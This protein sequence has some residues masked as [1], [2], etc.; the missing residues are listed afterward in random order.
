MATEADTYTTS[1]RGVTWWIS[2]VR[3]GDEHLPQQIEAS[4]PHLFPPWDRFLEGAQPSPDEGCVTGDHWTS[5]FQAAKDSSC[6]QDCIII[7]A[8]ALHGSGLQWAI[9]PNKTR[10]IGGKKMYIYIYVYTWVMRDSK[11]SWLSDFCWH[12]LSNFET[13]MF[14]NFMATGDTSNT[15]R[16]R[17]LWPTST[18]CEGSQAKRVAQ[19]DWSLWAGTSSPDMWVAYKPP[20]VVLSPGWYRFLLS[21]IY[22]I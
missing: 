1:P 7:W 10:K 15:M 8:W 9:P 2:G 16:C 20:G 21:N 11:T 3:H 14:K 19:D 5:L 22:P 4:K 6:L 12:F 13:L 18:G 17:W